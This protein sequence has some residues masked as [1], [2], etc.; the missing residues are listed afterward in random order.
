MVP[1]DPN[2]NAILWGYHWYI[3]RNPFK[4]ASGPLTVQD[5]DAMR[6]MYIAAN[7]VLST[8]A[9]YDYVKF[10]VDVDAITGVEVE[11]TMNTIDKCDYPEKHKGA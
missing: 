11:P 7:S 8:I 4:R 1:L 6:D 9:E 2:S 5:L 10:P 3:T